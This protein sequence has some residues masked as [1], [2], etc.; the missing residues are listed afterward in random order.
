MITNSL[1]NFFSFPAAVSSDDK[2]I[3]DLPTAHR[4]AKNPSEEE[5]IFISTISNSSNALQNELASYSCV[6]VI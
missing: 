1:T 2:Y 3:L 5:A 6:V 4:A